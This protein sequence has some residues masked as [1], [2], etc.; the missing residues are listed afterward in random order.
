MPISPFLC[1][2][3]KLK[4]KN[5]NGL[6]VAN[7]SQFLQQTFLPSRACLRLAEGREGEGVTAVI[8]GA[9]GAAGGPEAAAGESGESAQAGG[10]LPETGESHREDGEST[11]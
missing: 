5:E 9:R 4:L 2:N 11:Q 1:V 10:G 7:I 8:C 3:E 6:D